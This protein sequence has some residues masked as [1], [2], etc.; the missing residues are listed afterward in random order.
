LPAT[1]CEATRRPGLIV[2]V[3]G[4]TPVARFRTLMASALRKTELLTADCM[5][6]G[7]AA[8]ARSQAAMSN[9]SIEGASP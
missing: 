6:P 4:G 1:L 5:T 7:A 2:G 9:S 8:S 3:S